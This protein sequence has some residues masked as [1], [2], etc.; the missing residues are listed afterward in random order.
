MCWTMTFPG[1]IL[2]QHHGFAWLGQ[3]GTLWD[4]LLTAQGGTDSNVRATNV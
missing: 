2:N 1:M 4:T 3:P